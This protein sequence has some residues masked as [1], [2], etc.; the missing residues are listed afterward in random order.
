M[1]AVS[2][3]NLG[4]GKGH[5]K[6]SGKEDRRHV[7]NRNITEA[8]IDDVL[9]GELDP[10]V[11]LARVIKVSGG[12]RMTLRTVGDKMTEAALKGSLMCSKGGARRADNPVA[13][14]AGSFVILTDLGFSSQVIGVLNRVSVKAIKKCF[15]S[16]PKDFFTEGD[17][18]A[19]DGGFEWD[20]ADEEAVEAGGKMKRAEAAAAAEAKTAKEEEES[21][22][23]ERDFLAMLAKI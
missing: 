1:S 9:S 14:S 17:S 11:T 3:K 4:G 8:F 5:K 7:K 23:Y 6:G 12:G 2:K 15:P 22:D 20:L 10:A 13:V 16:A 19:D 21:S 18:E